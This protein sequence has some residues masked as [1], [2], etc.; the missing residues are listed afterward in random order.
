[1]RRSQDQFEKSVES[2]NSR[3]IEIIDGKELLVPPELEDVRVA[4]KVGVFERTKYVTGF[5]HGRLAIVQH[6]PIEKQAGKQQ[7]NSQ[8]PS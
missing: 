3:R 5:I 2:V 7:G 6:V 1:M 8:S 4:E